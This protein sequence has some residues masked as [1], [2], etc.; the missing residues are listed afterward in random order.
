MG[1]TILQREGEYMNKPDQI[2]KR[3]ESGL[4][5]NNIS[6]TICDEM[7]DLATSRSKEEQSTNKISNR[8]VE[9]KGE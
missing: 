8:V 5:G 3:K 7:I 1:R 6:Y 9:K 2:Q 4:W